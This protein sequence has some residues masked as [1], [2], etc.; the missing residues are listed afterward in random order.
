MEREKYNAFIF[1]PSPLWAY[2]DQ[3]RLEPSGFV[4]RAGEGGDFHILVVKT[5]FQRFYLRFGYER[6]VALYVNHHV[7][8]RIQS[9]VCLAAAVCAAAVFCRSHDRTAAKSLDRI[10]YA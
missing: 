1:R 3:K 8:I 5:C 2:W 7:G 6:L 10:I 9:V 4:E